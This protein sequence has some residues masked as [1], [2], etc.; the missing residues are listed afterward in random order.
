MWYTEASIMEVDLSPLAPYTSNLI[1]LGFLA[2]EL[3]ISIR[4]PTESWN[5]KPLLACFKIEEFYIPYLN[6]L[7]N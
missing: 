2:N 1:Q 7:I 6:K 3:Y 5:P 4:K